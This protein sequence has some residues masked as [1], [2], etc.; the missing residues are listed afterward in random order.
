MIASAS[1]SNKSWCVWSS[2]ERLSLGRKWNTSLADVISLDVHWL[3]LFIL[4]ELLPSFNSYAETVLRCELL[5]R[6]RFFQAIRTP[7][8]HDQ[9]G[10]GMLGVQVWR[11]RCHWKAEGGFVSGKR[12]AD[13]RKGEARR[14][15]KADWKITIRKL[16]ANGG[17]SNAT[18]KK[19]G[20]GGKDVKVKG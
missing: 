11:H 6:T 15:Q 18:E 10:H 8:Q 19:A 7:Q 20:D 12:K 3:Y 13:E 9:V 5:A 17:A 16:K 2:K 1:F 14:A 4:L